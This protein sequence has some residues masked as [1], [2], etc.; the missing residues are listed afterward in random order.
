[1]RNLLTLA[2]VTLAACKG[3]EDTEDTDIAGATY[4]FSLSGTGY[5]PHAPTGVNAALTDASGA[6]IAEETG[7]TVTGGAWTFTATG[8]LA[9]GET[10]TVSW[11]ADMSEAAGC[12]AFADDGTTVLDHVWKREIPAVTAAVALTHAHGTDFDPS[13][14]AAFE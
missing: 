10:Y 5:D 12:Q 8:A 7:I 14:C 6:V 9:E 3:G 11:Y 13:G 4:D 1:M 2:L